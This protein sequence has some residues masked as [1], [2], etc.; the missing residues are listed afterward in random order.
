M[1]RLSGLCVGVPVEIKAGEHRVAGLPLHVR[2][3]VDLGCRVVVQRSAGAGTGH[4]DNEYAS[5][6]AELV[7]DLAD[8]YAQADIVWKVKEILP[9]EFG[10]VRRGQ[11]IFT[12]LHAPPRPEMVRVLRESGCI[13]IAYEEMADDLGRRPLLAPMSRMAGAGGVLLAGQFGQ[14]RHGGCGKLLFGTDGAAP[15][16]FV[17][18]G[19]GVA[20]RAAARAAL[21]A[22]ALVHLL[23]TVSEKLAELRRALPEA[24]VVHS[25]RD[26][27]CRLLPETDVLMNCTYWMPGDPHV[28]TRDM[29]SLM[30]RGSLIM[31]ISADAHGAVETSETTTHDDPLR[32]V[33]GILHYCVQNIPALFAR[34]ASEALSA[35]TWPY[36]ERMA[37]DGVQQAARECDV[38]RSGVVLWRGAAVGADLGRIQGIETLA[39]GDLPALLDAE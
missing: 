19:G 27:L 13:A 20:G 25:D 21:G 30:R 15:M 18:L 22:G 12:Y 1:S 10:M 26:A 4:S 28:V 38:L 7:A 37:R 5:A 6:G 17:I 8:V 29:L 2:R 32:E 9:D 24:H 16:T 34:S 36:L 39:P 11:V 23:E 33:D 31:D 35:A 3:L 14:T